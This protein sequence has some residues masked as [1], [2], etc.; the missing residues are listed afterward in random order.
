[1]TAETLSDA[2]VDEVWQALLASSPLVDDQQMRRIE[3]VQASAGASTIPRRALLAIATRS[4]AD[5]AAR[6]EEDRA[7]AVGLAAI[8]AG[9]RA[10]A[11]RQEALLDLANAVIT[12]AEVALCVRADMDA[13]LA[14][15]EALLDENAAAQALPRIAQ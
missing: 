1:M 7:Y 13:V 9:G 8:V 14:E 2:E 15:G 6:C 3:A 10:W 12:R 5:L 4:G 11:E